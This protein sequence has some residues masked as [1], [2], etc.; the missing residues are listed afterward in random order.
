MNKKRTRT[1]TEANPAVTFFILLFSS[2]IALTIGSL[3][4]L[5]MNPWV[6]PQKFWLISRAAAISAY[7]VLTLI[8]LLGIIMSHPRNKDSWK[9][10]PRLLPWHQALVAILFSLVVVHLTFSLVDTKSGVTLASLLNP[11]SSK[12]HPWATLFGVIGFYLLLLVGFTSGLRKWVKIWLSV[13]RLSWLVWVFLSLH[14]LYDGTDT[15]TFRLLY[16]TSAAFIVLVF[17]WRHWTSNEKR[18][19]V[20]RK[21][22]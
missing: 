22:L 12:Y 9:V 7:V 13:H 14:G 19:P 16:E 21:N 15:L 2:V 4:L 17:F 6:Q 1:G 11:M 5:E 3:A 18:L 8:V 10:S 20:L